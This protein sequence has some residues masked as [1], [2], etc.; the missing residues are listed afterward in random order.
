MIRKLYL[1]N[2]YG[3]KFHFDYRSGC[4]LSAI[5]GLGFTQ[6]LTYLKYDSM[7]QQVDSTLPL[8]DIE[9]TITFL[10]GYR[11]FTSLMEYIQQDIKNLKLYY[12]SHDIAYCYVDIKSVS[13]GELLGSSLQCQVV[14]QKLSLWLK[15]RTFL[16]EPISDER[17]KKYPYTY[18]YYYP[19]SYEGKLIIHNRGVQKAPLFIEIIGSVHEPEVTVS[20]NGVLTSTLRILVSQ[21]DG[22]IQVS[23]IPNNQ[24]MKSTQNGVTTSVYPLQDFECEN[25]LFIEP[26]ESTVQFKPGSNL[27]STCRIVMLE[28]YLGV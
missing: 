15:S 9:A 4:L 23:S 3:N 19:A 28:G 17:G 20:K 7:Y 13:K 21:G 10:Q 6:E 22:V 26:G 1:E 16:I 11:G 24:F 18:P 12:E 14:F 25:F 8:Q 2:S 5:T 27:T